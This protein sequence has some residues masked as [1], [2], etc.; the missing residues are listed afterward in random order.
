MIPGSTEYARR[1]ASPR[2]LSRLYFPLAVSWVCMAIESPIAI[3][4]LSRMPD[5]KLNTAA[6]FVLMGVSLLIESPVIDLLSTSTTFSKTRENFVV[7]RRFAFGL[8]I[9]ASGVHALVALTPLFGWITGS[10]LRLPPEMQS[11]LRIPFIIF[12]PWS[13]MIGWRR[14][15]QGCLIRAGVSRPISVGTILRMATIAGV[16]YTLFRTSDMNGLTAIAIA[17]VCSVTVEAAF[18]FTIAAPIVR[19]SLADAPSGEPV[20]TARELLRFHLPLTATTMLNLAAAPLISGALARLPEPILNSAAWQVQSGLLWMAR[21]ATYALPEVVIRYA[22][23]ADERLLLRFCRNVGLG[24]SVVLLVVVASGLDVF[25][26]RRVLQV[27]EDVRSI[28]H[29]ALMWGVLLPVIGALGNFA[30]GML[31]A[32][33]VTVARLHGVVLGL[34]SL[35][36]SLA[37][38]VAFGWPGIQVAAGAQLVAQI[39]EYVYLR[40]AWGK[41]RSTV[42]PLASPGVT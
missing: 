30:R 25:V 24:L 21:T 12:I 34:S 28:A 11:V 40:Y 16:G 35:V 3:A 27:P 20:V 14:F 10:I 2:D 19:R 4:I 1:V 13:A 5:A 37:L 38:G 26:M 41:K 33:R 9:F 17:L 32:H 29:I 36:L 8:S 39:L 22:H 42:V 18:I 15:W 7:V 6:L 31:T 23:E